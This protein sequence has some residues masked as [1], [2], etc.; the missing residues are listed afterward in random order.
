MC[1]HI[2]GDTLSGTDLFFSRES[3]LEKSD[4]KLSHRQ[5][6]RPDCFD[7]LTNQLRL[8]P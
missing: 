8:V 4:L 5:N 1:E 7:S 3:S 6:N 2:E